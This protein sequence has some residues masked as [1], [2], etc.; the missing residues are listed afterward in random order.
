MFNDNFWNDVLHN[1]N[2]E[3]STKKNE[4]YDTNKALII[5]CEVIGINKEDLKITVENNI[6]KVQGK[7]KEILTGIVYEIDKS[8]NIKNNLYDLSKAT[9][10]VRNGILY[11]TLPKVYVTNK[12]TSIKID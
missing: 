8:F 2:Y 1:L 4:I 7:T 5:S 6:I 10:M 11:I 12:V 3:E 9:S